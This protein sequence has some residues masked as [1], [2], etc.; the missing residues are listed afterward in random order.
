M[1]RKHQRK[2]IRKEKEPER[3]KMGM[4]QTMEVL[5]KMEEC[6]ETGQVSAVNSWR[7]L[8]QHL[9]PTLIPTKMKESELRWKQAL[10]KR[11]SW[12]VLFLS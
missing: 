6:A 12:H 1:D 5:E 8:K 3:E 7:F 11:R 4:L 10:V 9:T 2:V